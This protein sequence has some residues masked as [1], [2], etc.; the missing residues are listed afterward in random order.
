[1]KNRMESDIGKHEKE[2]HK[3]THTQTNEQKQNRNQIKMKG[4]ETIMNY[5]EAEV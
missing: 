5:E 3:S 4:I 2:T 1:M